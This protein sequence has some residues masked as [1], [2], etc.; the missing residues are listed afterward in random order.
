MPWARPKKGGVGCGVVCRQV[1]G[2]AWLWLWYGLA[3]AA[4]IGP[5]AWEPPHASSADLKRPKKKKKEKEKKKE[6]KEDV[7]QWLAKRF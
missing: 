7:P 3:A 6:K 4:P 1:P 2:L 5:L